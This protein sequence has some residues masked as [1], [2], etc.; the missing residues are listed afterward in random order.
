MI[1][2][3]FQISWIIH[4]T[5]PSTQTNR[6]LSP[7]VVNFKSMHRKKLLEKYRMNKLLFILKKLKSENKFY[8]RKKNFIKNKIGDKKN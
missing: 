4:A 1:F 7:L 6:P 8:L 2:S 5:D 3:S